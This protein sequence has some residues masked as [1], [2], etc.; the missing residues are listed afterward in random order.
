MD[1]SWTRLEPLEGFLPWFVEFVVDDE[2][3]GSP[4]LLVD[5]FLAVDEVDGEAFRIFDADEVA[6]ARGIFHFFHAI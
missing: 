1:F 2:L 5:G 4:A 3:F 6:A